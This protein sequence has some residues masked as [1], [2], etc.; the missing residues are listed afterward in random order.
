MYNST[1][2]SILQGKV[3]PEQQ[4]EIVYN[5]KYSLCRNLRESK[6]WIHNLVKHEESYFKDVHLEKSMKN[7]SRVY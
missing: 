5:G 1:V 3:K 2:K 6:T 7:P 4:H